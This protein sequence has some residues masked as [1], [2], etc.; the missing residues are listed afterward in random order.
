MLNQVMLIGHV[1]SVAVRDVGNT[2]VANISL[3]TKA[4][5]KK[6]GE[7]KS[8]T[9]WHNISVWGEQATKAE[10]ISK[11]TLLMV[12][13]SLKTDEWKDKQGNVRKA[14]KINASKIYIVTPLD[15]KDSAPQEDVSDEA[16]PVSEEELP[17]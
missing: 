10:D 15:K 4:S 16:N 14:T 12:E 11:G 13:G 7:W 5:W 9:D 6:D 1:G 8:R 3:A 2:K 17:F